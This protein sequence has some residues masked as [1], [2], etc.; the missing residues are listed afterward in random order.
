MFRLKYRITTLA[1]V[2]VT[3]SAGDTNMVSTCDYIPGGTLIGVFANKYIRKKSIVNDAHIDDTFYQWFLN[4]GLRF[5]NACIIS[6]NGDN[7]TENNFH[8]PISIQKEKHN[9]KKLH[10]L[11]FADD[12]FYDKKIQT[13]S[14]GGFGRIVGTTLYSQDV[15]KT[16]SFHHERDRESGVSKEGLI[17]NYESIDQGQVFEGSILGDRVTLDEF[18]ELFKD[19][20]LSYIGRSKN[21]QYGKVKIEINHESPSELNSKIDNLKVDEEEISLTLLSNTIIFNKN[22]FSSVDKDDLKNALGDGVEIKK[23]FIRT[24]EVE[25]FISV[26]RLRKPSMTC[27]LAGSCF[28][29]KV[30]GND[31][32]NRLRELVK[33]GIGERRGEGFGRIE[34]ELKTDEELNSKD[35]NLAS[36]KRPEGDMPPNTKE[37]AV[38]LVKD[39]IKKH[40]E[41]TALN[42]AKD[43]SFANLS[44]SLVSRLEAM[45]V[46]LKKTESNDKNAEFNK[47]ISKL[48]K[49]AADKLKSCTNGNRTLNDFIKEKEIKIND[50]MRN[51]SLTIKELCVEI[52]FKPEDDIHFEGHLYI[53]YFLTFLSTLRKKLKKGEN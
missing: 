17:F 11:L 19:D 14:I 28:L 45:V 42:E 4:G 41:L 10:N 44:K 36:N 40:V 37:I 52:K 7:N 33:E 34:F 25:N 2:L 35:N 53:T 46:S 26:W 38:A 13:S 1:P 32:I 51:I 48:R 49:T 24:G 15:K 27:I 30:T 39:Y 23:T 43:F 12:H 31:N 16:I 21:A 18:K 50:V 20:H 5:S 22:G 3:T 47:V 29:L 6:H 8:F 9:E